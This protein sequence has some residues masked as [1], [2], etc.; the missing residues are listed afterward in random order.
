MPVFVRLLA[1]PRLFLICLL[2]L[3]PIS[4]AQALSLP[5]SLGGSQKGQPQAQEPLGQSLDEVIK[6][7]ENDQ[8]RT[9]LLDDLKKLRDTTKKAQPTAE[10]GV[11]GLIGSTLSGF[12]KQF[13]GDDS[14]IQRWSDELTLAQEELLGLMLPANQWLPVIFGFAL[15]MLLWSLLAAVLIWL[16]HRVRLRFGLSEELPQHPRTW[17]MLRFALRKLGPDRKSVV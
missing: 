1:L 4:A 13:S 7:L 3:I 17:D 6:T 9:K 14:P 8:Q 12:E 2:A 5:G 10:E 15:V 11:L 16:S